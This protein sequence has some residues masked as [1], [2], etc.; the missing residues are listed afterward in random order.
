MNSPIAS[1]VVKDLDLKNVDLIQKHSGKVQ[2][3]LIYNNDCLAVLVVPYH[4]PMNSNYNI[5][6]LKSQRYTVTLQ[7]AKAQKRTSKVFLP[8][9]RSHFLFTS[10]SIIRYMTSLK[11]KEHR[12]GCSSLQP[13]SFTV[14]SSVLKIMPKTVCFMR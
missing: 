7:I 5:P 8:V 14:L 13:V 11:Q 2:L 1:I 3:L 9:V 10:T 4:S 12:N 6:I